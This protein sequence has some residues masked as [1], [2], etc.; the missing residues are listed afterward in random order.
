MS[1]FVLFLVTFGVLAIAFGGLALGLLQNKP[2]KGSCGG[3]SSVTGD[4]C[5][6]CGADSA[7]G[8]DPPDSKPSRD[9]P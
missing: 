9:L 7:E 4:R 5:D 3:L 1:D 2:L 6:F 8:C